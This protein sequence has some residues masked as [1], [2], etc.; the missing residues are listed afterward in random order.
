M[1]KNGKLHVNPSIKFGNQNGWG[2]SIELPN[3]D[4][5]IAVLDHRP[6]VVIH[7]QVI[8][9]GEDSNDGGELPRGGL[10]EHGVACVLGFVPAEETKEG[11][12]GEKGDDGVVP[13]DERVVSLPECISG[14]KGIATYV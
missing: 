10:L 6:A 12:A 3:H 2:A 7:I 4:V 8:R 13:V 14:V 1:P 9:R 11:V 5:L